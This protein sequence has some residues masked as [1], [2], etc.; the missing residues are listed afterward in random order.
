MAHALLTAVVHFRLGIAF[1]AF[2][3]S[4]LLLP[5]CFGRRGVARIGRMLKIV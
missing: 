2:F 1:A 5:R 3:F 4:S